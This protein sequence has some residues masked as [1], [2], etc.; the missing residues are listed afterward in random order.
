V[1]LL[2]EIIEALPVQPV[3]VRRVLLGIH[4]TAVC[5][6]FCGLA[7]TLTSENLPYVDLNAVGEFQ[8]RSAQD[9]AQMALN[10]N[11]LEHSIGVAAIN[12]LLDTRSLNPVELNA[13]DWIFEQAPGKTIA[14]VGHFPF[15]DKVRTLA[16]EL[17]QSGDQCH[18]R[19]RRG[20]WLDGKCAGDV[21]PQGYHHGAGP[22]HS[23]LR[24][25]LQT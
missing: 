16:K 23:A 21:Q 11:H 25:A 20:Q 7:S 2:E 8:K 13:Y 1:T 10:G 24:G 4:W 3:P 18:H 6:R 9:L 15:V 17:W 12:S 22:L 5:S 14:I 19:K